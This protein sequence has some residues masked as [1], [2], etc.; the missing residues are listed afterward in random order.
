MDLSK[1]AQNGKP[2]RATDLGSPVGV[3]G[4]QLAVPG[5]GVGVT[6]SPTWA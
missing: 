4:D 1:N 5:K 6:R 3:Q 2:P